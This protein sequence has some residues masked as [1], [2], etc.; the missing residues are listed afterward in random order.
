MIMALND[1]NHKTSE[2]INITAGQ[3]LAICRCWKSTSF[4]LCDGAHK[5]YNQEK[6]DQLGPIIVQCSKDKTK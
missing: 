6:Q 2:T 1:Q 3:R 4:P 5:C